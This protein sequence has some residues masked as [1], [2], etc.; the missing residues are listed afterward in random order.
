VQEVELY[1][2][3]KDAVRK[4]HNG[5]ILCGGVGT[6]KSRVA[7]QYYVEKESP[8]DVYV[9]TTAKKRDS[10]D[11]ESEAILH[12]VGSHPG[13]VHRGVLKVDSWNN[14][15]RYV[16]VEGAFFVFDEQRLVGSGAWVKEWLLQE[17]D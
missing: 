17:Q 12:G 15:W 7:M 13:A 14:L 10:F 1:P 6:G 11:W 5:C 2:H 8:K 4:L 9:I 16:D 3:Q